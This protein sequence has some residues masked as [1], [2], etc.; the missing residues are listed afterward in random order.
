MQTESFDVDSTQW[1]IKWQ[2]KG[3]ARAGAGMFHVV[4]DSAVSGRPIL[5]AVEQH[6]NGHGIADVTEDPRLYHLVVDSSGSIGPSRSKKRW[7]ASPNN[8]V[9]EGSH[10]Q[11]STP[12]CHS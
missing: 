6:G 8:Q 11:R 12:P 10:A 9:P 3:A 4:V 1:R 7:L 5:D 2:T